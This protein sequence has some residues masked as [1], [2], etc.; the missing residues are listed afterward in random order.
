VNVPINVR[1]SMID[2]LMLEVVKAIVRFQCT[3]V[4]FRS[5]FDILTHKPL[6]FRFTAR[7]A[8]MRPNRSAAL[9]NRRDKNPVKTR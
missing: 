7:P 6:K 2:Y 4:E 1:L 3:A 8:H 9:Q 5:G